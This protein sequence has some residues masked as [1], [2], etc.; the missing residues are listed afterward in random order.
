M[1]QA[2]LLAIILVLAG[3]S[4]PSPEQLTGSATDV[5]MYKNPN[6]GCC[7]GHK[8]ALE[9]QGYS[10]EVKLQENVDQIKQAHNIPREMQSCHTIVAENYFIEGHVPLEAIERLFE[11]Q[12]D[13]DGIALPGMPSGTPGMPG[14]KRGPYVIYALKDGEYFEWM[15]I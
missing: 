2:I 4:Q 6:C 15:R 9:T 10:V 3:C 5:L 8:A 7:V 1:K 13:I 11:E 12:P 14:P